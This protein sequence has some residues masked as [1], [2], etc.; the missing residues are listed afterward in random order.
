[1]GEIKNP[2]SSPWLELSEAAEFV[3]VHF[4]TLRRW[5][6]DGKVPYIRTPGGRR[7]FNR[8]ELAAFLS[9]LR[10]G[11]SK[12]VAMVAE[13]VSDQHPAVGQLTHVGVNQEPWYGRLDESQRSAMRS[14]GQQLM[15]VLMQYATRSNGGQVF[16]AEGRR[17][18][19]RYGEACREASLSLVET[20]QAFV[21]VRRS[22]MDS[23]YEAGALAGSPDADTWRLY[24]RM[25]NF[26]DSMLLAM[27]EAYNAGGNPLLEDG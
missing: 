25:N 1:M 23:V 5:A 16:L 27:L 4:T 26:L 15:A 18:A 11:E 9:S 20:V 2:S 19:T 10:Q 24:D 3:G 17:L 13:S 8:A 22:I 6:N 21:R 14:E 7:R 12:A